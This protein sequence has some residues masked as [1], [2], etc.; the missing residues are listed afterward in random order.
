M[1]LLDTVNAWP[2]CSGLV[3]AQLL[4]NLFQFLG[5]YLVL[6]SCAFAPWFALGFGLSGVGGDF[7]T[8]HILEAFGL[9]LEL[10]AQFIF[11]HSKYLTS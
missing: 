2:E 5:E 8:V 10:G 6:D 4:F 3:A 11:R 1:A 7:T 9:A